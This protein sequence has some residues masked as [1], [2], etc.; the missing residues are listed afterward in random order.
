[1]PQPDNSQIAETAYLIWLDEGQPDG[2]DE[3]HWQ[4]ARLALS[5][6]TVKQRAKKAA[7]KTD[8]SKTKAAAAPKVAAPKAKA[9]AKPRAPRKAKAPE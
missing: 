9:P 7:P 3:D 2:H 1:M 4:R 5:A 6:E 8:A